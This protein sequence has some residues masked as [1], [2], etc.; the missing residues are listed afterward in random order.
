MSKS[1]IAI[2]SAA[3]LCASVPAF[4]A[5]AP[6]P[7]C[8]AKA[9]LDERV[10][11]VQAKPD[12]PDSQKA[13]DA[14]RLSEV[15]FVL[16][17]VKPGDHVLDFGAGG[18]YSSMILSAAICDGQLDSQFT[19]GGSDKALAARQAWIGARSNIHA[20][21]ADSDKLPLPAKPYDVIFIGTVYHDTYNVAGANIAAQDK[22]LFAALKPGGL[23]L[24]TDHRT[25]DGAGSSQTNTLHRIDKKTV[26]DDFKAAGFELVEDSN[27]LANPA[28]DHTLKVF[29]PS[30]RGHTD[31]MALVFRRPK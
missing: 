13:N 19:P 22:A 3:L 5:T 29:D 6:L 2:A 26:L 28:D 18:G 7:E 10:A 21:I 16:A 14:N 11:A 31:R 17:H 24:L 30:L 12:R 15:K 27:A 20:V 23:L 25:A 8:A 1:L 9:S 4:A